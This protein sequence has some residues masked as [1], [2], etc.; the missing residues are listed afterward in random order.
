MKTA[1][2]L[3]VQAAAFWQ[4]ATT[5]A[6]ALSPSAEPA[7]SLAT[8]AGVLPA[9]HNATVL[10]A[11][12]VANGS[13]YGE[14]S[15]NLPYPTDPTGLPALCA[16]VVQVVADASSTN[17]N[18]PSSFRFGVFLPEATESWN[19]RFLV[20]GNGGFAGGINWLDM[21][22]GVRYGFAVVST[23]TGHNSSIADGAWALRAPGA[24]ADFGYRAV[25][26]ATVLGKA[27][28]EAFYSSSSQQEKKIL[29]SYYSGAS[30]GGR[31][32]LRE[33]QY[34][35]ASFDGLLI[36]APAWW[37]SHL[38]P[39]TTR[40]G[41]ANLPVGAPWHI[42]AALFATVGDEVL[43]QCDAADGV[44][45]GIVSAPGQ[46]AFNASALLCGAAAN[47]SSSS[48]S[49]PCL[50]EAQV[51]TLANIYGDYYAEGKFAF[52]GLEL[53]SESQWA[54]LLGGD[55]PNS[56]GDEYI[57]DFLLDDPDWTWQE[58]NDSLL[59]KA[60]AEDPGEATA[61]HYDAMATVRDRGTKM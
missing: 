23:D 56:L 10:S 14:G 34:D 19:E 57:Q 31:Q 48:S 16:L 45:D 52:P 50:T 54:A 11:V 13:T 28:T 37:T 53:G 40:L 55:A 43:A 27:L 12:A 38:Q 60:D 18:T 26:G 17:S 29:K 44:A 20:V 3:V 42:P 41:A 39:W 4:S 61:D 33:A 8:F 46:C 30:T 32:G 47:N 6:A 58:Y 22:A 1:R 15:A 21:G 7:C 24:R 35:P 5:N 2:H 25:H 9:A 51:G 49:A 59:W 36:G